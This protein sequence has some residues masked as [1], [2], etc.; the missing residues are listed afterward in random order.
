MLSPRSSMVTP[1]ALS[2]SMSRISFCARAVA[3]AGRGWGAGGRGGR[4]V[5]APACCPASAAAAPPL[6][7]HPGPLLPGCLRKRPSAR[8]PEGPG[9][10]PALGPGQ[11]ASCR[12]LL[13]ARGQGAFQEVERR[14]SEAWCDPL[15]EPRAEARAIISFELQSSSSRILFCFAPHGHAVGAGGR[16]FGT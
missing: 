1:D 12:D 3:Q 6:A 16:C 11:S 10:R 2:R 8:S 14:W 4:A 5:A 7:L 15:V 13:L 9:L